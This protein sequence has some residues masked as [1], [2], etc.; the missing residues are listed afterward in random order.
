V[1]AI[2]IH[3]TGGPEVMHLE[4]I[5]RP[6]PDEGEVLVRVHAASVNPVDWKVRR[7]RAAS[8]ID[9]PRSSS[10]FWMSSAGSTAY[11]VSHHEHR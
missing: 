5:D 11:I 10:V 3:E 7:G 9:T 6:E 2:V 1:R 8:S 4:D